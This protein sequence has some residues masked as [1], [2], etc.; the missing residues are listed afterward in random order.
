MSAEQLRRL[1]DEALGQVLA[2][3][4]LRWAEAADPTADVLATIRSRERRGVAGVSGLRQPSRRRAVLLIA[5]AVLTLAAAAGAARLVFD[6]GAVTIERLPGRPTAP[7]GPAFPSDGL[8]APITRSNAEAALGAPFGTPPALAEPTAFWL[9]EPEIDGVD[10]APW[11]VAGWAAS[12][13][14]PAIDGTAWG[15]LL[16]RFDAGVDVASKQ[17]I[18]SSSTMDELEIDGRRALWL[19]GPHELVLPID[20]RVERFE[21]RGNV[22]LVDAGDTTLRFETSLA[23]D[24]AVDLLRPIV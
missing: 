13:E 12:P 3:L 10:G 22:L 8:G 24:D 1:D 11:V 4:D 17:V 16:T 15:A 5:A 9:Q 2:D 7:P 19:T 18:G 21:V 14:L 23:R 6:I 20:G